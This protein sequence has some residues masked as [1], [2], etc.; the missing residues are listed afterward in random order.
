MTMTGSFNS[1]APLANV[2]RL[3]ALIM[4]CRDRAHGLPGMGCFHGRA[5]WGKTTAAIYAQNR[6]DAVHVEAM[7]LGG[8]R[9]LLEMIVLELGLR[10]TPTAARLFDQAAEELGRTGRPLIID[11]AD[12]CL[13]DMTIETIRRL[14]EATQVPV[15]L[16]GEEALPQKLQRWERVHGRM[17]AWVAAEPATI[18]DVGHLVPI[19]ARGVEV[20]ADLRAAILA[21][22]RGS[23]RYVSTNL[24]AVREFAA[25]RGLAAVDRA[26]WGDQPMHTGEPPAVRRATPGVAVLPAERA[27]RRRGAA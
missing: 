5:G 26:A 18:E 8:I 19:Y 14:Y 25:V 17:L 24:A 22:S 13:K 6:L 10:P 20:H 9:K 1:V 2:A 23:L 12:L 3:Q 16:C 7:S 15:I 4:R 11:E 27:G 21:A